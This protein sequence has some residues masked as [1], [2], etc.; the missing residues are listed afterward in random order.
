MKITKVI[1]FTFMGFYSAFVS[2]EELRAGLNV[3]QKFLNNHNTAVIEF[4]REKAQLTEKI[5][6]ELSNPKSDLEKMKGYC[7]K[8]NDITK[9]EI[10]S[11]RALLKYVE[12]NP[13][14]TKQINKEINQSAGDL[15]EVNKKCDN[16]KKEFS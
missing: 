9:K 12:N 3:S 10:V 8:I 14:L 2:A 6:A 1:I 7:F 16:I 5:K 11:D 13:E 15:H 4:N